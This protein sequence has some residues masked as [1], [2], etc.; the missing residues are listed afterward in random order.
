MDDDL[1][2][3]VDITEEDMITLAMQTQQDAGEQED[4][5]E[6][7]KTLR[8]DKHEI[9]I[10]F[11][12]HMMDAIDDEEDD[13]VG[14]D[15]MSSATDDATGGG[16]DSSSQELDML[17]I[18]KCQT[19]PSATF[20]KALKE[21]NNRQRRSESFVAADTA[22]E[23]PKKSRSMGDIPGDKPKKKTKIK[24]KSVSPRTSPTHLPC[25]LQR[26]KSSQTPATAAATTTTATAAATTT[27]ATADECRSNN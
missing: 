2:T 17:P 11:R 10:S 13:D 25:K 19:C 6:G 26:A 20:Q 24:K 3:C 8:G 7:L 16:D 23:V 18:E 9:V 22:A 27:T 4:L 5:I 21:H 15:D 14:E 12:S 1:S